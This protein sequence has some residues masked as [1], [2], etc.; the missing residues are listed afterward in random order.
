MSD[1][2]VS[3]DRASH[4]VTAADLPDVMRDITLRVKGVALTTPIE[5]ADELMRAEHEAAWNALSAADRQASIAHFS[6]EEGRN[7][8]IDFDA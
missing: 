2:G 3:E 7:R 4:P 8:R 6:A 5:V 1:P